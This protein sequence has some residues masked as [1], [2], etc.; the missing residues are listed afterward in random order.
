MEN[1]KEFLSVIEFADKLRV[2]PNTIRKA[3]KAGRIQAIRI[4]RGKRPIYR[5]LNTEVARLSELDMSVLIDK[6]IDK[7]LQERQ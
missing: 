5:I 1:E 2:H 6:M 4:G 3:I 7:K